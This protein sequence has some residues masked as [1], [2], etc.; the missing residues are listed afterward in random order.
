MNYLYLIPFVWLITNFEPFHEV[1]DR[2]FMRLPLNKW[3]LTIHSAFGCAKCVGFWCTL[4]IS[5][6]FFTAC[7]VSLLSFILDRCLQRLEY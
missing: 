1:I 4:I 3:T 7:L 6:N 5:G 2:I